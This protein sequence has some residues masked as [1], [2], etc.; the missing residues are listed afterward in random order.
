MNTT[1][2]QIYL[3][4]IWPKRKECE[5][6]HTFN[7]EFQVFKFGI[8]GSDPLISQSRKLAVFVNKINNLATQSWEKILAFVS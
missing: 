3:K 2:F 7:S 1:L 6:K 8:S 5:R 4:F